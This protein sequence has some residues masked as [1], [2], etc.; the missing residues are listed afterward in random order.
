MK[1]IKCEKCP[2]LLT[3]EV[4]R[5]SR[6]AFGGQE[7]CISCQKIERRKTMPKKMADFLNNKSFI[8]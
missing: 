6:G 2:S 5:Y 3:K 8:L 7:L 1:P 4:A